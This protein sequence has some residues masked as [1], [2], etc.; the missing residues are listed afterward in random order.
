MAANAV[1]SKKSEFDNEVMKG[2]VEGFGAMFYLINPARAES[3]AREFM[4]DPRKDIAFDVWNMG[5]KGIAKT[6]MPLIFPS[7]KYNQKIYIP[8]LY[9][10]LSKH[11]M[12]QQYEN[13]T[14]D[15]INNDGMSESYGSLLMTHKDLYEAKD[16]SLRVCVRMLCHET[17]V[18][19][20]EKNQFETF[21][22]SLIN[23]KPR[24]FEHIIIHIRNY[25]HPLW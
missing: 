13:G 23:K 25:S 21:V 2:L 19:T 16:A 4:A 8:R 5:E 11:N 22:S 24:V 1:V 14:I 17:L 10:R 15:K 9:K 20:Q 3:K 7:I 18:D 6:L 12:L